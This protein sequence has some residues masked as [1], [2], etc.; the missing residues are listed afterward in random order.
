MGVLLIEIIVNEQGSF[1]MGSILGGSNFDAKSYGNLC[2]FEG[3]PLD[4]CIPSL[5]V[6]PA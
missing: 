2:S 6:I 5:P 4:Y 3:F 1:F